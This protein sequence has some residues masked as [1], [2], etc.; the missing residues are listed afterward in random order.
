MLFVI[1]FTSS[2]A[3]CFPWHIESI[4]ERFRWYLNY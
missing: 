2:K 1:E 3:V 4:S